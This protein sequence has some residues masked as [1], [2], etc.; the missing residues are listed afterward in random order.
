[1]R[2]TT[3]DSGCSRELVLEY[4][5]IAPLALCIREINRFLAFDI[6][7]RER[8]IDADAPVLDVGCGDGFWWTLQDVEGRSIYGVDIS[9]AEITRA[10]RHINAAMADIS[11]T[12]PFPD[13]NFPTIVANCSLEHVLD[14]D[15]ALSVMSDCATDDGQLVMFVPA[16]KWFYQGHIQ[17]YLLTHYPRIAMTLSGMVNGFFQHWHLYSI[18]VWRSI[19]AQNNWEV[20]HVYGLGNARSEMLFRLLLPMSVPGFFFKG[21]TG[22]Y[23]NRALK[24]VPDA[25]LGPTSEVVRWIM[26]NPVVA[27][28]SPDAYEY[29]IVARRKQEGQ[30]DG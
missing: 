18:P 5:R 8:I 26:T 25:L 19:L 13:I 1:M 14:I 22:F 15:G 7:K 12:R 23:P 28:E 11:Q 30:A 17:K 2:A 3:D 27:G 21:L 6:L 16:M 29:V 10:Q 24:L 20:T 4:I 9:S